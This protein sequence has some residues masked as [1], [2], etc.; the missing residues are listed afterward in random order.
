MP[1]PG[2]ITQ[3]DGEQL[4]AT[5]LGLSL[6]EHLQALCRPRLLHVDQTGL[7]FSACVS[8]PSAGIRVC[9]TMSGFF[10]FFLAE[11]LALSL[12]SII[13]QAPTVINWYV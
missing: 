6:A 13:K 1:L 7:E 5:G 12:L 8:F 2:Y 11:P 10:F 4:G 3:E 9:A